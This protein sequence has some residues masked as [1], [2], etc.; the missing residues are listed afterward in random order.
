[1]SS[2]RSRLEEL[3]HPIRPRQSAAACLSIRRSYAYGAPV[4]YT[5]LNILLPMARDVATRMYYTVFDP[6]SKQEISLPVVV[7]SQ[8]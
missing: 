8:E 4:G 3:L 7:G 6:F 1:M 5:D 2:I